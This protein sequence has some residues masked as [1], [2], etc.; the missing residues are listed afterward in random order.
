MVNESKEEL[1]NDLQEKLSDLKN[2]SYDEVT[3][4]SMTIDSIGAFSEIIES[5]TAKTRA[6]QQIVKKDF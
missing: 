2:R 5:I 3:A 1:A 4:C 6:L